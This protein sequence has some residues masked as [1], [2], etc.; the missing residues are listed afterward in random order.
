MKKINNLILGGML[1]LSLNSSAQQT[2]NLVGSWELNFQ[3]TLN[4][5]NSETKSKY[6]SIETSFQAQIQNQLSSQSFTF[7]SDTTFQVSAGGYTNSGDWNI[8]N[9][10]LILTFS[11]GAQTI[12][13]IES[14]SQSH[15]ILEID[16]DPNSD[17]LF[18]RIHLSK[19]SN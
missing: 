8:D 9:G 17:I 6:D 10:Q 4:L 14:L 13:T 16:S 5:M 15:L 7:N 19:I 1:M 2:S 12:Q 11:N 3:E 18:K